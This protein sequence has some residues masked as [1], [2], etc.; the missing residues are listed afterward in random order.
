MLVSIASSTRPVEVRW[1]VGHP[2]IDTQLGR[3]Q[4]G[5]EAVIWALR[6]ALF[7]AFTTAMPVAL[8][9][10]SGSIFKPGWPSDLHCA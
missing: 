3:V 9:D 6:R 2:E 7:V 4:T 5:R 10:V 1:E 8:Q